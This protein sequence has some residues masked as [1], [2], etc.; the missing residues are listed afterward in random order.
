MAE[1]PHATPGGFPGSH[2]PWAY[3]HRYS[4]WYRRGPG[5]GRRLFWFGLG[6]GTAVIWHRCHERKAAELA[7][8]GYPMHPGAVG[9]SPEYKSSADMEPA[10]HHVIP[11][12]WTGE[13]ARR[14]ER[15]ASESQRTFVAPMAPS[16]TTTAP[17]TPAPSAL[18]A[19]PPNQTVPSNWDEERLTEYRRLATDAVSTRS[20]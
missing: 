10:R 18:Q 6:V 4:Y 9:A 12:A 19:T 7:R 8:L 15:P 2:Y 5:F 20:P 16:F 13:H 14:W 1:H 11:A 17:E 3:H